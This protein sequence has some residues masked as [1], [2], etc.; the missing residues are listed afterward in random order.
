MNITM[1]VLKFIVLTNSFSSHSMT[2]GL[3]SMMGASTWLLLT[4]FNPVLT[5]FPGSL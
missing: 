5:N 1:T 3:P 4:T 2:K